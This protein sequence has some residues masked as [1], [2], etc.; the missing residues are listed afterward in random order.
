MN[1]AFLPQPV[2][3]ELLFGWLGRHRHYLGLPGTAR[4][5]ELL[6]GT[7]SAVASPCLQGRLGD[8]CGRL[9]PPSDN[10]SR[11]LS[12]HS[13]FHYFTAFQTSST[14]KM[15]KHDLIED[16]GAKA[17]MKLG[18]AAFCVSARQTALRVC[19]ECHRHQSGAV[20]IPTWLRSHQLPGSLVCSVHGLPLVTIPLRERGRHEFLC[21][22]MDAPAQTP[23][24][25]NEGQRKIL[26]E[27]ACRQAS[28][29]DGTD[30]IRELPEWL[31]HYR[32]LLASRALMRSASKVDHPAL[33]DAV[34]N[35]LGDVLPFLPPA[36]RNLEDGGWPSLL[37]RKHRKAMHPLFHVLISLV[38]DKTPTPANLA[39]L[40]ASAPRRRTLGKLRRRTRKVDAR[41]DWPA[42]DAEG[43]VRVR[44]A[45]RRLLGVTPPVRMTFSAIERTAFSPGWLQ[46]RRELVPLS[47]GLAKSEAE[48]EA[49]F[50]DRRLTYWADF[51]PGAADWEI[52]RAAGIRDRRWPAA[53]RRLR[54]L[55]LVRSAA[56]LRNGLKPLYL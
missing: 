27:I 18:L 24:A 28:L 8:L 10:P 2:A 42:I 22:P 40:A 1:A 51:L 25:W 12:D 20:G 44:H 30:R 49:D 46:K 37:V 6:F 5:T 29:L 9:P 48:S 4:H 53:K 45:S 13:L 15:A 56:K 41:R 7:R 3:D 35:V 55:H 38:I 32:E 47:Y 16:G 23:P 33:Q 54:Q 36:C 52:C 31:P 39:P 50:L 17:F 19:P 34:R 11:L 43:C 26:W 14:I 21:P